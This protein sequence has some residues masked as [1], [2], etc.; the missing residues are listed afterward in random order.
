[1]TP[2]HSP[3]SD[4]LVLSFERSGL[5]WFMHCVEVLTG[6]PTPSGKFHPERYVTN[7]LAF[8]RCHKIFKLN[9]PGELARNN[10]WPDNNN[11][12]WKRVLLI[13]R[14]YKDSYNRSGV[15]LQ[16][17]GYAHNIMYFE[18]LT[19]PKL[20]VYYDDIINSLTMVGHALK[21]LRLPCLQHRLKGFVWYIEKAKSIKQYHT[22]WRKP[23]DEGTGK[24]YP[25]DN[26]SRDIAKNELLNTLPISLYEKYLSRYENA[27]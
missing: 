25:C 11:G 22:I 9:S 1:M 3:N 27:E 16:F 5:N 15:P 12:C 4:N 6:Y 8:L 20:V 24:I 7:R 21:F 14:D 10:I 23:T 18:Q 2:W 17:R 26:A 19:I 13:L